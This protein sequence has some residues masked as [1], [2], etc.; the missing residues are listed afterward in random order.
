MNSPNQ[1]F[2]EDHKEVELEDD[3]YVDFEEMDEDHE[4]EKK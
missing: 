3:I 4:N 2:K 1:G